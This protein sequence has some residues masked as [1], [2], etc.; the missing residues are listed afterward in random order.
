MTMVGV[1]GKSGK[2]PAKRAGLPAEKSVKVDSW[3]WMHDE[4]PW[5]HEEIW[6]HVTKEFDELGVTRNQSDVDFV[7]QLVDNYWQK[8]FLMIAIDEARHGDIKAMA[9]AA[10]QLKVCNEKISAARTS[11]GVGRNSKVEPR[12]KGDN[13]IDLADYE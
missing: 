2:P 1:A 3:P 10:R 4:I 5:S 6:L 13:V 8:Q 7:A 12:A 11:L 9:D